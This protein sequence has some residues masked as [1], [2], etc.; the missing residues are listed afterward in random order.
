[1][2]PLPGLPGQGWH[3]AIGEAADP[4]LAREFRL[5]VG[6]EGQWAVAG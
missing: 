1:M 5:L 3:Q 4:C 2:D 6:G